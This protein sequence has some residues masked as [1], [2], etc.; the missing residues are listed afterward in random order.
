[1]SR[2]WTDDEAED[3]EHAINAAIGAELRRERDAR[4]ITR[5]VLSERLPSRIGDRAL[6][7][8]EN[9][10]VIIKLLRLV[11]VA[12]EIGADPADLLRRGLQRAHITMANMTLDVDLHDLADRSKDGPMQFRSLRQW[13]LN[14]LN[15]NRDG[16]MAVE[17]A[18]VRN[19]ALY[20]GCPQRALADYLRGFTPS[21]GTKSRNSSRG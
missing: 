16:V 18:G 11:E 7:S 17:T 20:L 10:K 3:F 9:G 6:L 21:P 1:M 13:A 15:E 19:L 14:A 8:I 2:A 4:G 12:N 5:G